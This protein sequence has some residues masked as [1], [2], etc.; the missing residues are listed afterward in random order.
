MN[1]MQKQVVEFHR[2]FDL[3]IEPVPKAPGFDLQLARLRLIKEELNELNLG[4]L[5]GDTVEIADAIG[6]LLYVVF[7]TAVVCGID[8]EPVFDEIHRSNMTKVGGH[9][10]EN[11]KWIK[12]NTYEPANLEPIIR[13]Q[14]TEC[15]LVKA[16]IRGK[17]G[18]T[19]E[20]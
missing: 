11:G 14:Q 2:M 19:L 13:Q 8:I 15:G 18:V 16:H 10:D 3:G 1:K 7:G 20:S 6:D 9:K 5:N 4:F 17:A 12:P